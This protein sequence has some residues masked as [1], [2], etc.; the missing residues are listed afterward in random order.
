MACPPG[1]SFDR[2]AKLCMDNGEADCLFD[3]KALCDDTGYLLCIFDEAYE[4]Q[5]SPHER[6]DIRTNRCVDANQA[7][8]VY[9]TPSLSDPKPFVNPCADNVGFN[10]VPDPSNCQR[11]FT[12][13]ETESYGATC[14]GNQIFDIVSKGCAPVKQATC[15]R[16]VAPAPQP[17]PPPPSPTPSPRPPGPPSSPNNPCRN[18]NGVTYK[19]HPIDCTRYYMCMDTQSIERTCPTDQ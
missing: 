9:D 5:C 10:L 6:Y 3:F 15:I 12:C 14:P 18:N 4:I 1:K 11:Y 19:P 7:L 8:C 17:P 2:K 16:D 13:I